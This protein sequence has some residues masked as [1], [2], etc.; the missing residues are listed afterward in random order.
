MEEDFGKRLAAWSEQLGIPRR[1]LAE[2]G[3][4]DVSTI[5]RYESGLLDPAISVVRAIILKGLGISV[6]R[7]WGR[8]PEP[9]PPEKK[10]PGRP[11]KTVSGAA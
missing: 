8:L 7:F 1:Q 4:V 5:S 10:K 11:R 3:G 9:P 2:A 6:E